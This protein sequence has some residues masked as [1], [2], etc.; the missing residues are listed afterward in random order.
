MCTAHRHRCCRKS[1]NAAIASEQTNSMAWS[2]C[3]SSAVAAM[4]VARDVATWLQRE[5]EHDLVEVPSGGR[6]H[7]RTTGA[8]YRPT[9]C[10][11]VDAGTRS[12]SPIAFEKRAGRS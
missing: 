9:S 4:I 3:A 1:A 5:S 6:W 11:R 7:E 8:Y 10:I 12:P 2:K